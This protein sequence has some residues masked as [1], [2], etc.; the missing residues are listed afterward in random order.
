MSSLRERQRLFADALLRPVSPETGAEPIAPYRHSIR[1][2]YRNALGA[3]YRVVKRLVGEPFFDA[4][5]DAYVATHPSGCAD[6]N[7]YGD[8][9]DRFLA[10]YP[11]ARTLPY[12]P[13]VARLEWAIDCVHNAAETFISPLD[14]LRALAAIPAV[15]LAGLRLRIAPACRFVESPFPLLRIYDT[16]QD[17]YAGDTQVSL[18]EGGVRLLVRRAESGVILE[19][20]SA[21]VHAWLSSLAAGLPLGDAIERTASADTQFD[22]ATALRAHVEASTVVGVDANAMSGSCVAHD[23]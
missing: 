8:R 16:N 21:G 17:G 6:L 5:V 9:F 14:V 23:Q 13:D 1:R 3:T 15:S 7:I 12:L 20:I 11:P 19:P 2:N 22:F 4:A 18:D 10:D